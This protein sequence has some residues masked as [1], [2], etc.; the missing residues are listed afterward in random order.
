M[1]MVIIIIIII[2]TYHNIGGPVD[3]S[4]GGDDEVADVALDDGEW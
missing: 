4:E 1:M 2:I 3:G